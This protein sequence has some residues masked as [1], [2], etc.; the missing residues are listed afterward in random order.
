MQTFPVVRVFYDFE[1]YEDGH[2]ID[3]ISF[4]GITDGGER[5][6]VVNGDMDESRVARHEW[7]GDNVWPWLPT[8]P[9]KRGCRCMQGGRGHLDQDHPDVRPLSQFRRVVDQ[10]LKTA[11]TMGEL[12]LWADYSAYDH[13]ALAQLYGPMTA[14]PP[15]VPRFT[16]DIQQEARRLGVPDADLPTVYLGSDHHALNDAADV[17]VRYEFLRT[18]EADELKDSAS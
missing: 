14:L 1:F 4:G 13:V 11:A 10:L 2:V 8:R 17:R 3:P 6:Y 16:H 12:E 15:Y 9:C 7:L 18:V 5:V